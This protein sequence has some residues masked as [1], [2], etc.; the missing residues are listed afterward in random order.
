MNEELSKYNSNEDLK[1]H[2]ELVTFYENILNDNSVFRASVIV[3]SFA[4]G[5]P[6]RISDIDLI[7]FVDD[8]NGSKAFDFIKNEEP[9][10]VVNKY[11]D[12]HGDNFY[13]KKTIFENFVSAEIHVSEKS[14]PF[15]LKKPYITLFDQ[16]NFLT[17]ITEEGEAPKHEDFPALTSG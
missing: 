11:Q 12:K 2:L 10:K 3:G 4:K 7:T 1:L 16:D 9:F 13:Y 8:G 5:H 17:S 6:D 14:S 15:K